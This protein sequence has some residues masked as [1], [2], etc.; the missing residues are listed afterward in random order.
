MVVS[1]HPVLLAALCLLA[2][3]G[4]GKDGGA[5]DSPAATSTATATVP[6]GGAA[7]GCPRSGHWSECQVKRRLEQSGLAPRDSKDEIEG[8]PTLDVKPVKMMI[9]S[10][11]AALY[12]FADTV[13]R[14]RAVSSLDT[15][16]FIVYPKPVGMRREGTVIQNDNLLLLLFS[17]NDHQR[18][19]VSDAITAGAPQP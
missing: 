16:K 17:F 6:G 1:R 4:G 9:G 15:L 2:A 7:D 19:R 18:E 3:C 13:A 5:A 12:V 10:A 11:N 14:R 8:L